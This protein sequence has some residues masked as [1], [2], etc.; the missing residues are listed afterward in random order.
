MLIDPPNADR[1][2]P[3][4]AV[5]V[6]ILA[7]AGNRLSSIADS[8]QNSDFLAEFLQLKVSPN[9][10]RTYTQ[11]LD[12]FFWRLASVHASIEIVREF[13]SLNQSQEIGLVLKYQS[14]VS[15]FTFK[16]FD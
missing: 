2:D 1:H 3:I 14:S 8:V 16:S 11:C 5:A 12:D 13:L 7:S 6:G 9:T 10:R 4:A 15:C